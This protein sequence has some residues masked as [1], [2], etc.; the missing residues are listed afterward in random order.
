MD[1][2]VCSGYRWTQLVALAMFSLLVPARAAESA[3]K[4]TEAKADTDGVLVHT[5]ECEYQDRPTAIRVLLPTRLE[6]G[7]RHVRARCW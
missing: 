4:I 5:V 1:A 2:P 6:K 7:R 3:P